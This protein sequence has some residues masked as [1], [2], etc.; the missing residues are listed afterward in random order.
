MT[1]YE[2]LRLIQEAIHTRNTEYT[3]TRFKDPTTLCIQINNDRFLVTVA[4]P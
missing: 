1:I 4:K 2:I 3:E